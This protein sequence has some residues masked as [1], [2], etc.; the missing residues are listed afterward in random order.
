MPTLEA[1]YVDWKEEL[2][3]RRNL[4][5]RTVLYDHVIASFPSDIDGDGRRQ[6]EKAV[7]THLQSLKK[8]YHKSRTPQARRLQAAWQARNRRKREASTTFRTPTL[9]YN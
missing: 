4:R 9:F 2:N 6:I 1:Y 8:A 7:L 5:A 3:S